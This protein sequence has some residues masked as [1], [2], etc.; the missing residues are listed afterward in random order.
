MHFGNPAAEWRVPLHL[1]EFVHEKE[2]LA[3]AGASNQR[4]LGITRMFDDKTVIPHILLATHSLQVRFPTLAV[5]GIGEHE[6]KLTRPKGIVGEGRIFRASEDVVCGVTLSFE[7]E[8]RLTDGIGFSIYLLAE[9]VDGHL[10]SALFRKPLQGLLGYGQHAPG[11]TGAVVEEISAGGNAV[12][13][14][15]GKEALP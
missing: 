9:E 6:I 3:V 10:L 7:Q 4:V 5:W 12:S 2:H 14:R 8:I 15:E 13:N 1:G 11:P